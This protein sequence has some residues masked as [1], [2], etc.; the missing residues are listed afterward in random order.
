MWYITA[1][2]LYELR[3]KKGTC[4]VEK[5]NINFEGKNLTGNSGL[6]L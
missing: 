3:H 5:V 1:I 6:I 2:V 4:E